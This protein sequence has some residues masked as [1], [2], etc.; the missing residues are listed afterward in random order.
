MQQLTKE[1]IMTYENHSLKAQALSDFFADCL[2]AVEMVTLNLNRAAQLI[3]S[4]KQV[5]T[6]QS[7][8]IRRSFNVKSY[9]DEVLLSLRPNER[10]QT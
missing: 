5:S 4:F 8:E 3:K 7:S 9:L 2:E 1:I 10:K 6:D